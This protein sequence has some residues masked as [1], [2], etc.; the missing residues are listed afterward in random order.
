MPIH[1]RQPKVM[2][3]D[4]ARA[5]AHA[6]LTLVG[7]APGWEPHDARQAPPTL[8]NHWPAWVARAGALLYQ[9]GWVLWCEPQRDPR[10]TFPSQ[11]ILTLPEGRYT[12]EILDVTR[13]VWIMRESASG[14]T[15]VTTLPYTAG[16][17]LI[18]VR[19]AGPE[20]ATVDLPASDT[21]GAT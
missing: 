1:G 19:P 10:E 3:L 7:A 20:P 8:V 5:C 6:A 21:L 18:H 4:Q 16:T 9:G 13:G 15:L 14:Q 17:L 11:L 12:I 2:P